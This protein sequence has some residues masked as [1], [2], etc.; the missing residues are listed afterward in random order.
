MPEDMK[1]KPVS[2]MVPARQSNGD[3]TWQL[4]ARM[5][6][7]GSGPTSPK[8]AWQDRHAKIRWGGIGNR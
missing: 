5:T 8:T 2:N 6:S 7:V 3:E 4:N 1:N